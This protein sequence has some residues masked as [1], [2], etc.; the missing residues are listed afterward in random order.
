MSYEGWSNY[1]TWCV[2]LWWDNEHGLYLEQEGMV[3]DARL[4][5]RP[6][7]ALARAIRDRVEEM[8]PDV[9][10]MYGDLLTAA[11]Q[12]ADYYEVADAWLEN[13]PDEDEDE[14]AA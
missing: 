12:S 7:G 1:E 5:G 11:I 2:A 13:W 8:A 10:G 4:T 6:R 9:D 3:A 14:D